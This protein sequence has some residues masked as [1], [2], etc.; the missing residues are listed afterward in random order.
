MPFRILFEIDKKSVLD[1]LNIRKMELNVKAIKI[2]RYV[3]FKRR[4]P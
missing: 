2:T 4:W 3:F 1:G